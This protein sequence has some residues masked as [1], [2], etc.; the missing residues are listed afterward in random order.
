M[1]RTLP[2]RVPRRHLTPFWYGW[3]SW[4]VELLAGV[5]LSSILLLFVGDVR[6]AALAGLAASGF[7]ELLID[8]NGWSWVDVGQ[9]ACGQAL[10]LVAILLL[11]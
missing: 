2:C 5:L 4:L 9:R 6:T 11:R 8:R 10:P 3:N 1:A 7:Y